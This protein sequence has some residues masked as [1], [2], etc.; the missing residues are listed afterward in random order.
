[1]HPDLEL[2]T[3]PRSLLEDK[4]LTIENIDLIC[5]T[6]LPGFVSPHLYFG[7]FE[8]GQFL[9]PLSCWS[10]ASDWKGNIRI[11]NQHFSD[12]RVI[13][14]GQESE[15]I[16]FKPNESSLYQISDDGMSLMYVNESLY[17]LLLTLDA[18]LDLVD[19]AIVK[20]KQVLLN[21]RVD[22]ILVTSFITRLKSLDP[23]ASANTS[24]WP[25]LANNCCLNY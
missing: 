13:G 3:Y 11:A 16:V 17:K 20:D 4:H 18:F 22:P 1:M 24:L 23:I 2:K 12:F 9:P 8:D 6:G 25:K 19:Q 14:S 21:R 5:K 15:P 10:W 7:D